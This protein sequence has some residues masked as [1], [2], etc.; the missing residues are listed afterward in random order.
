MQPIK[1]LIYCH[2]CVVIRPGS[3]SGQRVTN[4]CFRMRRG[5][6]RN[7][8]YILSYNIWHLE[9]IVDLKRETDLTQTASD[10][11]SWQ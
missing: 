4:L 9:L 5:E 2:F 11:V 3:A 1:V 7:I 8:P 6:E 10:M